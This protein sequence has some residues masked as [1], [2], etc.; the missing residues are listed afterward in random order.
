[1]IENELKCLIIKCIIHITIFITS[2]YVT[3]Y[4][5]HKLYSRYYNKVPTIIKLFINDD[6]FT[7]K[8]M[9]RR[10]RPV[11]NKEMTYEKFKETFLAGYEKSMKNRKDEH[12]GTLEKIVKGLIEERELLEKYFKEDF[13]YKEYENMIKEYYLLGTE[14][15]F[16]GEKSGNHKGCF[17][18]RQKVI[19]FHYLFEALNVKTDNYKKSEFIN[20][21]IDYNNEKVKNTNTPK[22]LNNIQKF[23]DFSNK[24]IDSLERDYKIV[25]KKF[26]V[27]ELKECISLMQKDI[28]EMKRLNP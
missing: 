3:V 16:G 12:S 5:L 11:K 6:Y 18:H 23:I 27:I 7:F 26:E 13:G 1:M 24:E 15:K 9:Y 8:R 21:I 2:V 25:K 4:V 19:A 28:D 17:T 10:Y 22:H 20:S 14:N